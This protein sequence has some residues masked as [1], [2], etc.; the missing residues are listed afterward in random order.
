MPFVDDG[1]RGRAFTSARRAISN[2][3]TTSYGTEN[4]TNHFT[5]RK[6]FRE[7]INAKIAL[8]IENNFTFSVRRNNFAAIASTAEN[9]QPRTMRFNIETTVF[10]IALN[11]GYSSIASALIINKANT[12]KKERT[13][14]SEASNVKNAPTSL[15]VTNPTPT[16]PPTNVKT[17][18]IKNKTRFLIR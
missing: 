7:I 14:D 17:D 12:I 8:V 18:D 16:I 2:K 1:V 13:P 6:F 3:T 9:M 15:P 4:M 10:I 5:T 11:F